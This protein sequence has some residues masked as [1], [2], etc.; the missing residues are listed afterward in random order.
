[1]FA[2]SIRSVLRET[3]QEIVTPQ[4]DELKGQISSVSGDVREV[5]ADLQELKRSNERLGE[6]LDKLGS[7]LDSRIDLLAE[8]QQRLVEQIGGLKTAADVSATL[9]HRIDRL[10]DKVFS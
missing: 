8:Q 3:I 6:R 9:L 7:R 2:R 1:M 4:F 10:E 5:K